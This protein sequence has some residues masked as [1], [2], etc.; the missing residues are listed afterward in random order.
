MSRQSSASTRRIAVRPAPLATG[1]AL[2]VGLAL[3]GCGQKQEEPVAA[4]PELAATPAKAADPVCEASASW[5]SSPNP[6][7]EVDAEESFCDFYQ[8]SWQWFLAQTSLAPG[9][10]DR[11]F[12]T[13]RLHIPPTQPGDQHVTNQCG[14]EAMTG[15]AAAAKL[16]SVRNLKPGI[17]LPQTLEEE[18]ADGGALYDQNGNVVYYNV[19]YSADMC[20]STGG[21]FAPGT[22]E[23]K[24]A[25]KVLTAPDPSYITMQAVLPGGTQPSTLALVGFH[26]ANWTTK[27]PEM[28]WATFEHKNNVPMCDGS[29]KTPPP[30]GWNFASA[31][32]A[33]CLVDN[34]TTQPGPPS[35]Q[36]AAFNFN[37][38]AGASD[39][40]PLTGTPNNI[41]RQ[42]AYGNQPGA[43]S[44]N[45]NDNAAN[46]AAI[47]QLNQQL[48]GSGG[49]LAGSDPALQMQVLQNYELIGGIWTKDGQDSTPANQR[50]SLYLANMTMESF[51]EGA[52]Q[53]CFTC[54]NFSTTNQPPVSHICRDLFSGTGSNCILPA[55]PLVPPA[56][57]A[58][59]PAAGTAPATAAAPAKK[60]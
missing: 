36:C 1:L 22:M 39:Q 46:L 24:V 4:A 14:K 3:A 9:G 54:H 33:Q 60:T 55:T 8:F 26:I 57:S 20:N 59:A 17:D 51:F 5:I 32:A 38:A 58:G 30:N 56:S 21:S 7:S 16:L 23:I 25:W 49:L 40:P 44:S 42:Y 53:N 47:Q 11:V 43:Q 19:W 2:V 52:G 31:E 6:P 45:G 50:G 13:N 41:C 12:E 37:T 28:I 18:Q 29:S 15:R 34:P 27:H 10:A 35:A 48:V